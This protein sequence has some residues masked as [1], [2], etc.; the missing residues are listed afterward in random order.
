MTQLSLAATNSVTLEEA[1]R[2]GQGIERPFC[3]PVHGDSHASASVNVAK[4]VW[5]CYACGATGQVDSARAPSIEEI[6]LLL[7]PA[8]ATR[9][10]DEAYLALFGPSAHWAS[11][12]PDWVCTLAQ[13]GEDPVTGAATFPVRLADG[14]LA[15]VGLR[16]THNEPRYRYPGRWSASHTLHTIPAVSFDTHRDIVVLVEG[17]ADTAACTEVGVEAFGC[18]GAGLHAAQRELVVRASPALVLLGY[19]TDEAGERAAALAA[20]ALADVAPVARVR[21][22]HHGGNDPADC[23]PEA[24]ISALAAAVSATTYRHK[25]A[26]RE[27]WASRRSALIATAAAWKEIA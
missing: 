3:C 8:E 15:G 25:T 16:N 24:R 19:D 27:H 4:G 5:Y 17:A 21:W 2:L 6:E 1:L 26:V 11:R 13:F 23:T 18:Y 12:F 14:R 10:V 9:V 20:R 7:R 22:G